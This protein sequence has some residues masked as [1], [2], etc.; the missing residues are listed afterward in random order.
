MSRNNGKVIIFL[1]NLYTL[2]F[3]PLAIFMS[4]F[5]AWEIKHSF[6]F[7]RGRGMPIAVLI[8]FIPEVILGLECGL[9]NTMGGR[10]FTILCSIADGWML[11]KLF[12][13][14]LMVETHAPIT[15]YTIL[16][17]IMSGIIWTVG[18]EYSPTLRDHLLL[19][20]KEQ[21]L[22]PNAE[23]EPENSYWHWFFKILLFSMIAI[24]LLRL[25]G[26]FR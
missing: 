4:N 18:I 3:F 17:M 5:W 2:F 23:D 26:I 16:I 24:T 19:Y 7:R 22:V 15:Y 12:H 9:N 8:I 20:P 25:F 10:I 13:W 11:Y 1:Y 6:P 14:Y 21:W